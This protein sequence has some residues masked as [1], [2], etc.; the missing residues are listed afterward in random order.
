M[1]TTAIGLCTI[2]FYLPGLNSLKEKRSIIKSLL[3]RL[4][5]TFNV[6]AAEVDHLDTWRSATLA[7]VVV[8]G[9][10]AHANKVINQAL[11]WVETNYP[12][13]VIV[14]QRIEML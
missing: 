7:I 1:T 3:A 10:T 14:K 5:N 12:E 4:H 11:N 9:T 8:S 13:A 2:E 6:S